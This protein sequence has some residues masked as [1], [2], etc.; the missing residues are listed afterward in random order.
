MTSKINF[1]ELFNKFKDMRIVIIGDV[2]LDIFIEGKVERIN[3][4]APIPIVEV[5]NKYYTLGGAA[6]VASNVASLCGKASLFGFVGEDAESEI[7]REILE[8]KKIENYLAKSENTITKTRV[9]GNGQQVVRFDKEKK[10]KKNFNQEIIKILIRK[11]S[12]A[13]MIVI[14]DYAKGTITE[15]LLRVLEVFKSKIIVDPKPEN[16][17]LY[18]DVF[19]I[20][21]NEKELFGMVKSDK[22]EEAGMILMKELNS[23]LLVTRSNKG[24]ALFKD[25]IVEIPTYAKEVYDVIGVGDTVTAA[26]ALS[27][28]AGASLEIAAIVGNY[29]AGVAISKKGVYSVNLNELYEV[30]SQAESK[31]IDLEQLKKFTEDMHNKNKRV[32]WTNGC[33]DLL[34]V[35]HIKYLK[36]AKKFGDILILGLNSDESIRILKGPHRPVQSESERAEILASLGFVDKVIIFS[37]L[38]CRN[39]LIELKPDCYVKG[40]DYNLD[41]IPGIE[42]EA[43]ESYGGDIKFIPLING[44]STSNILNKIKGI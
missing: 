29:A 7:I 21:P 27:I 41:T 25:S 33:F 35:G 40:G 42:R 20:K 44:K 1:S 22:L 30:I 38:D 13:N 17:Y 9:I 24:M 26:L 19:L 37:E 36:E 10:H 4:E 32:V 18:K 14:S 16:K 3:P 39:Y 28:S 15:E 5:N 11:C 43:V 2:M 12:D 34:H 8:Q 23:N 6:N 31:I